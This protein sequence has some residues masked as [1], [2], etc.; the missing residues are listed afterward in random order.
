MKRTDIK[1]SEQRREKEHNNFYHNTRLL[2]KLYRNVDFFIQDRVQSLEEYFYDSNR[3]DLQ[4]VVLSVLEV[5]PFVNVVKI[6]EC[7]IDTNV[8]ILL[9]NLMDLALTRLENYPDKGGL[10]AELLKLKYF[11]SAYKTNEQISEMLNVSRSTYYRYQN[12]AV[13]AYSNMLFGY[14]I[15]E[16][17]KV[18]E[19]FEKLP[20]VAESINS[21]SDTL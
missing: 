8:S 15:P 11:D 16:I 17:K 2:L 12:Q 19:E 14:A 18:L 5:D 1:I 10:Y 9:L 20:R 6:E 13:L 3:Q 4:E 21:Y 7:L